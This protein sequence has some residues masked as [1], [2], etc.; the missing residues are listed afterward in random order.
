MPD[1]GASPSTTR[2]GARAWTWPSVSASAPRTAPSPATVGW[3]WDGQPLLERVDPLSSFTE[4]V[5]VSRDRGQD[6][7]RDIGMTSSDGCLL[8]PGRHHHRTPL[9]R[10]LGGRAGRSCAC[11]A[12]ASPPASSADVTVE[13]RGPG[14]DPGWL[15]EPDRSGAAR[16]TTLRR[17]STTTTT[18]VSC[19]STTEAGPG[20]TV[21]RPRG[22][23]R[24][25]ITGT[26]EGDPILATHPLLTIALLETHEAVRPLSAPRR[27]ALTRRSGRP[28]AR[29]QRGGQ[30]HAVGD[31]GPGRIQLPLRRHGLPHPVGRT[32]SG[33]TASPTRWM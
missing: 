27:R 29:V 20:C 32:E 3:S 10:S 18:P 15:T 16:S 4:V 1:P 26:G 21:R 6:P 7:R 22:V 14:A 23:I 24:L 33:S 31:P 5:R 28:R 12:C 8:C 13:I 2:S 9:L 19:S 30:V 17:P 11:P 25:A